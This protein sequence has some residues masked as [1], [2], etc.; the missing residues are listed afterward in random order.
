M[1]DAEGASYFRAC[2]SPGSTWVQGTPYDRQPGFD[3]HVAY[4]AECRNRGRIVPANP[5]REAS[6]HIPSTLATGNV[7]IFRATDLE[8]A[9]KLGAN[10]P[11]VRSG[12]L[13]VD[14]EPWTVPFHG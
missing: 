9:L 3:E 11:T 14:V 10:D 5:F 4:I 13:R 7:T 1:V 8:E 12:M 6:D 2:H